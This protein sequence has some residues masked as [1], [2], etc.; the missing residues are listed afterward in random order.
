[1]LPFFFLLV[2]GDGHHDGKAEVP[3][4]EGSP[5]ESRT[6]FSFGLIGDL[7]YSAKEEE[8]FP[9]LIQELNLNP[10][11]FV[12]HVGDIKRGGSR[13]DNSVYAQRLK[14][15]QVS[16]HPFILIPGDND[17]TDCHRFSNGGFDP[18]ERLALLRKLFFS[19][20]SSLGQKPMLLVRQSQN[21]DYLDFVENVR[22][23]IGPV[24][25]VGLHV[26]G[27]NNNLGRSPKADLEYARRNQANL[28][29]MS[30][31]F[32]KARE[33]EYRGV[34]MFIHGNPFEP[35]PD[36]PKLSGFRD[37]LR[38]L[39]LEARKFGRPV[40]LVHGD[41]HYFRSDKPLPRSRDKPR[42]M[43]FTRVETFGSPTVQWIRG[44]VDLNNPNLFSFEP[45]ALSQ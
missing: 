3:V 11:A 40:A 19:T 45:V 18:E 43:L 12:V 28:A 44:R 25:F 34:V 38:D 6:S 5:G 21:T 33:D 37:F 20:K 7:P 15:F 30:E 29:W 31:S 26:V 4:S 22:W 23:S 9:Y 17:W 14:A 2:I 8:Q 10:L 32:Q 36:F 39:E 1:M 16:T 13:C 27:S 35:E 42:L 41:T 24:L